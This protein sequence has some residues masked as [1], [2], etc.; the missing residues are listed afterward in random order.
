MFV[1]F[2]SLE[3]AGG[4]PTWLLEWQIVP[5][6][7]EQGAEET[8]MREG[9]HPNSCQDV[10]LCCLFRSCSSVSC[11][12][13]PF[14]G[15]MEV[16]FPFSFTYFLWLSCLWSFLCSSFEHTYFILHMVFQSLKI[17]A[18]WQQSMF[19][20]S[21]LSKQGLACQNKLW[22]LARPWIGSKQCIFICLFWFG[23]G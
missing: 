1:V 16:S 21:N 12:I 22:N 8:T 18:C 4:V 10:C 6:N 9:S 19:V 11:F 7:K 14:V 2:F 15:K 3:P 23:V 17:V 20:W 13:I 5:I